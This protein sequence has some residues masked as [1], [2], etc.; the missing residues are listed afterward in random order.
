MIR[1]YGSL[2]I[3]L[4]ACN[5]LAV[6]YQA[7][8]SWSQKV[9]LSVPVSGVVESV[10]ADVGQRIAKG[11]LLLRL[12]ATVLQAHVKQAQA[13]RHNKNEI[14]L[15]AQRELDRAQELYDR[16]VLSDHDLQ[17]A[18]NHL[19]QAK[20]D[21]ARASAQLVAAKTSLADSA[22][23]APYNI[24]ILQRLVE[25]GKVIAAELQAEPLFVVAAADHMLADLEVDEAV[26]KN[27]QAGMQAEVIIDG[28]RLTGRIKALGLEPVNQDVSAPRYAVTVM[29]ATQ[30]KIF[31]AGRHVKVEIK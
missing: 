17:V 10:N 15:E 16:T 24:L 13:A 19:T 28:Q 2:I 25:P 30:G 21:L 4:Y 31:P 23:H 12:D 18:K 22:L 26:I 14:M 9:A 11:G 6:E 1:C 7:R 29:F 5:S 20:A 27:L 3:L 8:L